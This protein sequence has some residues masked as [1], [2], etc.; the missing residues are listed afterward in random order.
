MKDEEKKEECEK[1]KKK[2]EED[3]FVT[4]DDFQ[5]IIDDFEEDIA[6]FDK[7]T[8][9]QTQ[10]LEEVENMIN[11]VPEQLERVNNTINDINEKYFTDHHEFSKSKVDKK[12]DGSK[13][14][15]DLIT[16]PFII[17]IILSYLLC[18]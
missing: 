12:F 9:E 11:E 3:G 7:R 10:R 4:H 8:R 13:F 15:Y 14:R 1:Y 6:Y 17:L 5:K 18:Q 16:I 2:I